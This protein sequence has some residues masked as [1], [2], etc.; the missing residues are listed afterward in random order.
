MSVRDTGMGRGLDAILATSHRD[1]L[2]QELREVPVE[3]IEPNPHQPRVGFD[4]Q[5]LQSL[6]ASVQQ[7]GVLQPVLVTPIADGRYQLIAGERRWR[8]AQIAGLAEIPAIVR[9]RD[10]ATGRELALVE[11]VVREDLNP[12]ETANALAA[13]IAE[14]GCS[15]VEA[16]RRIGRSRVWVSNLLR[17]LE[18]PDD[19]LALLE[20]RRLSEGHGRALLLAEDHHQR[21]KLARDAVAEGLSVR[22]LERRARRANQHAASDS[23]ESGVAARGDDGLDAQHPDVKS[24]SV[25]LGELLEHTFGSSVAIRRDHA[26]NFTAELALGAGEQAL[27]VAR[28]LRER[29][30]ARP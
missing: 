14:L 12:V 2:A 20:Q 16:G 11:N 30:V 5:S 23:V 15:Q 8:A 3:L 17:L 9:R 7:R 19:V 18:L 29:L 25:E 10:D 26:G 22:A 4:E 21:R 13:L 28:A 6:A 1:G 24:L 27:A